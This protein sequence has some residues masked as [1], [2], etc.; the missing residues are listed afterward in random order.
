LVIDDEPDDQR[1][2]FHPALNREAIFGVFH[3]EEV[4][5]QLLSNADL[6]LVDPGMSSGH[7]RAA[8]Q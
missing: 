3:P 5:D 7:G 8:L 6:V 1:A 2:R 4:D